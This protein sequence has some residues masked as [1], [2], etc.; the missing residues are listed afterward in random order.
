M[1]IIL[2]LLWIIF[3]GKITTEIVVLGLII[4]LFVYLFVCK[5]LDYSWKTDIFLLRKMFYIIQYLYVLIC[6]I[7]KANFA[8]IK[9][10]FS[11]RYV[12]E[13]VLVTLKTTLKTKAARVILA[14]SFTITPGTITVT[15]QNDELTVH[16][17]DKEFAEGLEDSI[18]S[19]LLEK[20]EEPFRDM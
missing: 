7:V 17:L 10:I 12:I 14:N 5:F 19:K 3:N 4:A 11:S 1:Y 9:K 8:T 2:F 18:F 20:L 16:C 15:L 13:P 6:E